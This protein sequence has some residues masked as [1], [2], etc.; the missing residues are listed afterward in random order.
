MKKNNKITFIGRLGTYQ[1]LDMDKTIRLSLDLS[2]KF[3][4][5]NNNA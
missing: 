1:Y 2:E 4:S 5:Q 3:I